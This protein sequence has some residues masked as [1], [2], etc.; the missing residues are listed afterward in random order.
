[1]AETAAAKTPTKRQLDIHGYML[2][3]QRRYGYPPS[4]RAICK[5]LGFR[6]PR[7]V[8]IHLA[9]LVGFGFVR[10]DDNGRYLAGRKRGG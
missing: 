6:S 2:D 7:P 1:M 5:A 4:I 9:K 10:H 3:Y 8:Q